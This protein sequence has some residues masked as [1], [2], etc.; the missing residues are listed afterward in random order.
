[1]I[2]FWIIID[3]HWEL[4]YIYIY[5]KMKYKSV[6]YLF[7]HILN[8]RKLKK[9]SHKLIIFENIENNELYYFI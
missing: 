1:M 7:Y 3:F 6:S 4:L 2:S 9:E 8:F 5:I